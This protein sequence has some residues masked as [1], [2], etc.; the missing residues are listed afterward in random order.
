MRKE[1]D[2]E[3]EEGHPS[4]IKDFFK[5]KNPAEFF[6]AFMAVSLIIYLIASLIWAARYYAEYSSQMG[7]TCLWTSL[8]PFGTSR[9]ERAS[10]PIAES[11]IPPWPISSFCYA[12]G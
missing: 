5:R 8:I 9:R 1:K 3:R 11:S 2:V 10:I 12:F 4:P 6:A 7:P